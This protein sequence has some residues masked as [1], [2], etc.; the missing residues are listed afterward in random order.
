MVLICA[1]YARCPV[2]RF[3]T[4][5]P[6]AGPMWYNPYADVGGDRH[7]RSTPWRKANLHAHARAWHGLT[8][9]DASAAEVRARYHAMGYDVATVSNYQQLTTVVDAGVTLPVY[10]QGFNLRK[11]HLLALGARSVDW[12][13]FPFFQLASQKQYRID[14]LRRDGALPVVPHPEI[15]DAFTE[16]DLRRLTGYAALEVVSH[17]GTAITQWD[18]AL[19]AGHLVWALGN[20]DSHY[21]HDARQTGTAWTMIGASTT[22][23]ADLLAAVA[24]GRTYA[25]VGHGGRADVAFAALTVRGD[26]VMLQLAGVPA[27]ITFHGAGGRMLAEH[28]GVTG[29]RYIARAKDAYVR[30]EARTGTTRLIFNPVVRTADGARPPVAAAA[31]D[32]PATWAVRLAWLVVALTWFARPLR[33]AHQRLMRHRTRQRRARRM[34]GGA[35]AGIAATAGGLAAQSAPLCR[36]FGAGET[37]AYG[38]AFLGLTVERAEL[39]VR[40][41]T[42]AG[43][44][45]LRLGMTLR[46]GPLFFKIDDR[47]ESWIDPDSLRS[48]RFTQDLHEGPKRY[49]RLFEFD[50]ARPVVRERGKPEAPSVPLPLD[51][52]S[53]VFF[54]R[55]Q[56]LVVGQ[57]YTY[58]RYF[59]PEA[60]PVVVRVVR[61]ERVT[62]P[63]GTFDAFVLQ[64]SIKTPG[65]FADGGRAEVWIAADSTR[66]LL[67]LHSKVSFGAITLVLRHYT[68]GVAGDGQRGCATP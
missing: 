26:A 21:A 53:F 32:A 9:G 51:E 34:L 2:Y 40:P 41:D 48:Y 57:T 49:N 16:A 44:A 30:V 11:V 46:G 28:D 3:P 29:A 36:P 7:A 12:L 39:S 8:P 66:A 55:A 20:D 27:R 35:A 19:G 58:Q 22:R 43:R 54:I 10:E 18:A 25:V 37:A 31:V 52:A 17:Y 14:R 33:V 61:R 65:I 42:L 23:A 60:N 6:F 5:R 62:V 1:L 47:Q 24:A 63:A 67:K 64:P 38:A 45:V 56:P 4:P 59:R 68:P 15:R 50:P 13:D